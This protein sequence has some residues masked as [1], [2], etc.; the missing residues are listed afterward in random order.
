MTEMLAPLFLSNII[1]RNFMLGGL[2]RNLA[3][4]L[5]SD[6][7]LLPATVKIEIKDNVKGNTHPPTTTL[8]QPAQ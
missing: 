2:R 6:G 7:A 8:L 1:P 3:S 5:P 4:V